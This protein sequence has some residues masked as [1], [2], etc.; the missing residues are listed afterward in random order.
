MNSEY[1]QGGWVVQ[2][3]KYELFVI[4]FTSKFCKLLV[5]LFLHFCVPNL[6]SNPLFLNFRRFSLRKRCCTARYANCQHF[7]ISHL[8]LSMWRMDVRKSST[9]CNNLYD[10]RQA[11]APLAFFLSFRNLTIFLIRA[12]FH[13]GLMNETK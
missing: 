1:L 11:L 2:L 3:N 7:V 13:S 5:S 4:R 8:L 10:F 6:I 12:N 9:L